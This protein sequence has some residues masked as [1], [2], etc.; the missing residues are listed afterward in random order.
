MRNGA[1]NRPRDPRDRRMLGHL[2]KAMDRSNDSVLHRV[3][4]QVGNERI[5]MPR[6]PPTGPRQ[7]ASGRGGPR[8]MNGRGGM[9]GAPA[10]PGSAAANIMGMTPQQQ[11]EM[12]AML[13]QQSRMMAQILTPQQQQQILGGG[14]MQNLGMMN[15]FSQQQQQG[16]SLF[17]RVQAPRQHNGFRNGSNKPQLGQHQQ[18]TNENSSSSMDVQMSQDKS[19]KSESSTDR[20]CKYNLSCTKKDCPFAHQSPAAPPGAAIDP[21]DVCSF[22]A[23][24]KNYKCAGRHPSPALKLAHQTEQDC[25][26]FPNCAN[27]EN[28]PFR[29]PTMPIC[30]N[31]ADCTTPN[32]KF[33]HIKTLCKYNPCLIPTCTF[34]H[35]EGQKRGK[36]EDKV[37]VADNKKEHV[38][39]RKFVA[40]EGKEELIIPGSGE[41]EGLNPA[42]NAAAE[43]VT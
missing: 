5:N 26:F 8:M 1:G 7:Q 10:R 23:A 39:E 14:P 30:Y 18:A 11:Y 31:G 37:W 9:A 36:F 32:C 25:K 33:T 20:T 38:S 34:K 21:T 19:D 16:K 22:G 12:F 17:D 4:P 40:D 41:A 43:L 29:H 27:G 13:E 3:R 28:C 42:P 24:C 6:A 2:A 15:G 35:V